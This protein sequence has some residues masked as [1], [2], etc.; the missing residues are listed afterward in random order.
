MT[1]SAASP[2]PDPVTLDRVFLSSRSSC[3]LSDCPLAS[4][5]G[6]LSSLKFGV[7]LTADDLSLI[8]STIKQV[9]QELINR[10]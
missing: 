4:D 3:P 2:P 6:T 10:D 9:L 7:S 5:M 1:S 8:K